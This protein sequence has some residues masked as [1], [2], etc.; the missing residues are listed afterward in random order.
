LEL[1]LE[2]ILQIR[3]E[4]LTAVEKGNNIEEWQTVSIAKVI[5]YPVERSKDEDSRRREVVNHTLKLRGL[6][7]VRHNKGYLEGKRNQL[8]P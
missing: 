1:H 8:F 6:E 4:S 2:L 3:R 5:D 7:D